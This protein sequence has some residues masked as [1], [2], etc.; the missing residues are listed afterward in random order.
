MA[1]MKDLA[2]V[3]G[4]SL[5][6]IS[7]VFNGSELVTEKT[8]EIVLEAAKSLNYRPNKMAAALRSG[9]SKTIGVVVPVISRD[10]FV[11]AI[12]SIEEVL[13]KAG[14]NIIICQSHESLEKEKDILENL[15][16]LRVDGLIISLSKETSQVDHLQELIDADIPIVL[17]DRKSEIGNFNSIGI[18]NYTGAHL[19]TTHLIEQGCQKIIH[20]AGKESVSIFSERRR[21][22]EAALLEHGLPLLPESS[23]PFD[24]DA[25]NDLRRL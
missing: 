18:D 7:R 9:K 19:A 8:R 15:K 21:G 23:I 1:N 12:K 14:Y 22:F 24:D 6:T 11:I 17:F 5:A 4:L 20:L 16:Q 25:P 13:S 2:K 10:V 3:T